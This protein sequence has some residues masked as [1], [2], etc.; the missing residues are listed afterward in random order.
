MALTLTSCQFL[1]VRVTFDPEAIGPLVPQAFPLAE[2]ATGGFKVYEACAGDPVIAPYTA[3]MVWVDTRVPGAVEGT[4]CRFVIRGFYSGSAAA[5]LGA[6]NSRIEA[7]HGLVEDAG[8]R[9]VGTAIGNEGPVFRLSAIELGSRHLLN[10]FDT[11]VSADRSG[12]LRMTP[13]EFSFPN[14]VAS[15]AA[16]EV[17]PLQ[18][19]LQGIRPKQLMS[20]EVTQGGMIT[21][22]ESRYI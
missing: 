8:D 9:W 17:L 7:G 20:A 13:V 12:A 2:E 11:Y 21:F 18:D 5:V 6:H 16:V 4:W 19:G 14:T 22:H 10:G 3:A 1:T 15:P